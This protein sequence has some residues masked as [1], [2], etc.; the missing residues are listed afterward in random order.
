MHNEDLHNL[1]FSSD[2]ITVI[3]ARKVRLVEH[4]ARIGKLEMHAI[5]WL[6]NLKVRDQLGRPG[7][8]EKKVLECILGKCVGGC[9]LESSGSG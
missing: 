9:R 4:V 2:I 7:L 8:D 5:F 1:N 6:E 3:K